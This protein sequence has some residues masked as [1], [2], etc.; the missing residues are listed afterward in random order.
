M[1]D[2]MALPMVS[3]MTNDTLRG[4]I[5]E[6][7]KPVFTD[8]FYKILENVHYDEIYDDGE[9]VSPNM[10][11]SELLE[12]LKENRQMK[13]SFTHGYMSHYGGEGSAWGN[14]Y[15]KICEAYLAT[16]TKFSMKSV[17]DDGFFE[18]TPETGR[19]WL[20]D[21]FDHYCEVSEEVDEYENNEKKY[22]E[23]PPDYWGNLTIEITCESEE[24]RRDA[25]CWLE[26]YLEVGHKLMDKKFA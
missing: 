6:Y 16:D 8:K 14:A 24:E 12:Q 10:F 25:I 1:T 23:S 9:Y 3:V 7:S 22:Y 21:N 19:E 13:A 11:A 5:K 2:T 26:E 17:T 18:W 20:A 15:D 4:M